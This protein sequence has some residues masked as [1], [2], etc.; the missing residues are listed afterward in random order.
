MKK[1]Y[2]FVVLCMIL[3]MSL[4]A[5][6]QNGS[7]AISTSDKQMPSEKAQKAVIQQTPAIQVPNYTEV[8]SLTVPQRKEL[9]E[10]KHKSFFNLP[11]TEEHTRNI[12]MPSIKA[13]RKMYAPH[14]P[15]RT[16]DIQTDQFN[17][18]QWLLN[19]PDELISYL[20]YLDN[21]YMNLKNAINY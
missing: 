10:N 1:I 16:S 4:S 17:L 11:Y 2:N 14:F 12:I 5:Q 3:T 18:S 9:L 21:R 6:Q 19:Y 13:D 20:Q 15:E 7:H 8:H